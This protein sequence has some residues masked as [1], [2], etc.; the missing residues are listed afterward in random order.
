MDA[1]DNVY[2]ADRSPSCV[3]RIDG[4]TS[5]I[6]SV[7][8][9]CEVKPGYEGGPSGLALDSQGNLYFTLWGSNL[10]RRLDRLTGSVTT[11]GGNGLPDRRDFRD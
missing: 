6:R 2:F 4:K 9:T 11:V 8:R 5:E 10:V 3:R 7:P 1:Q